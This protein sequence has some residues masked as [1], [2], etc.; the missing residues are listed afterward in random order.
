[1]E[2]KS[3][4]ISGSILVDQVRSIDISSRKIKIIEK[5]SNET[6]SQVIGK[7]LTLIT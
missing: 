7:M 6:M 5:A 4:I 1:V 2:I 3:K